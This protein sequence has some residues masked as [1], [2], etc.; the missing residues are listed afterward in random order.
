MSGNITASAIFAANRQAF[1]DVFGDSTA[2]PES[3]TGHYHTLKSR[4]LVAAMKNNF[5]EGKSTRNN[6]TPNI[7]D[8]F[9]DVENLVTRNLTKEEVGKF[10]D[11]FIFEFKEGVFT[12]KERT[13]IEQ[14]IGKLLRVRK[15]SP[16]SRYFSVTRQKL[17]KCRCK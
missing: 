11:T 9:C 4:G 1:V 17:D 6:A 2:K 5:D 3:I 13:E 16:V 7:I 14:K 10:E 8:F 15:I 12:P